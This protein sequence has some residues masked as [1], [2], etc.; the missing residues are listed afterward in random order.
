LIP[1]G[2]EVAIAIFSLHRNGDIWPEPTK[3][4]PERFLEERGVEAFQYMPF[5]QGSRNCIGQQV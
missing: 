1:K 5:S 3:F 4:S 2:T